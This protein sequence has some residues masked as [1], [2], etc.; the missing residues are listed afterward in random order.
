MPITHRPSCF[1]SYNVVGIVRIPS[2]FASSFFLSP[3]APLL[4]HPHLGRPTLSWM[5]SSASRVWTLYGRLSYRVRTL[6]WRRTRV[7]CWCSCIYA[8]KNHP[9]ECGAGEQICGVDGFLC[10]LYF[11]DVLRIHLSS[12]IGKTIVEAHICK[13]L[14]VTLRFLAHQSRCRLKVVCK[15]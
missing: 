1:A 9:S 7:T 8:P 6:L 4:H 11:A 3:Y 5:T 13:Q 10:V 12:E 2:Y 15:C 14:C